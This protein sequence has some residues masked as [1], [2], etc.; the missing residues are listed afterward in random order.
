MI[1]V[2]E[3][4]CHE[5]EYAMIVPNEVLRA[6]RAALRLSQDDVAR[7]SGVAKRTILR[8]EQDEKV[9]ITTLKRVQ[10]ALEE[11]GVEFIPSEPGHGPGLR[12]P[13]ELLKRDDLRF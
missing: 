12:I 4:L 6:A 7:M 13:L 2:V 11:R 8:L 1:S 10:A 5:P 3:E 9:G